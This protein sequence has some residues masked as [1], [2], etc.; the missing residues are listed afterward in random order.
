MEVGFRDG[1]SE[2]DGDQEQAVCQHVKLVP[3]ICKVARELVTHRH[4]ITSEDLAQREQ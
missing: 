2:E 4:R 3:H 1:E